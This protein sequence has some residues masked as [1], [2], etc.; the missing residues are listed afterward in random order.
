MAY[1]PYLSIDTLT[2]NFFTEN[3][4]TVVLGQEQCG[5]YPIL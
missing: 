5:I 1:S 2:K 3:N 4:R